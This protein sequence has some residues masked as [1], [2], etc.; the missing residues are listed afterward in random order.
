MSWFARITGFT[1]GGYA[2]TQARLRVKNGRLVPEG[3]GPGHA[4]GK[5]ELVPLDAL[6]ARDVTVPGLLTLGIV[7][8]DVRQLHIEPENAGAVFQVASQFNLLEMTGPTVTPEHGVTGY[9]YYNTQGPA[10]AIAAGAGTIWRNYLVQVADRIGQTADRQLD[11]L[12]DLGAALARD[13]GVEAGSLWRMRNG[14]ALPDRGTLARIEAHLAGLDEVGRD[15][16]RRL[17]RI[18]LHRDVGVTE[19]GAA[20]DTRVTQ[21]Y[22]SALPVAYSGIPAAEWTGFACLILEAA[23]EATVL[24]AVLNAASGG[25]RRLLLTRIGGGAFGNV[26]DW[27]TA[28]I[29]RALRLVAGQELEV[30]IV[31]YGPAS[32]AVR[33]V[34]TAWRAQGGRG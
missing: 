19:P 31:S 28:A 14:Y 11:G 9:A 34:E 16:L 32:P 21:V 26:E 22:C 1:E 15:R 29:L 17:L 30:V 33:A 3:G 5:L 24:S 12:A 8:G 20:P 6:R 7:E 13:M 23:Y 10:C 25:S 4:V 2:E 27:I 18:G